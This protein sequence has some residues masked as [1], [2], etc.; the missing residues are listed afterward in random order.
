MI[1]GDKLPL[2]YEYDLKNLAELFNYPLYCINVTRDIKEVLTSMNRRYINNK[3]GFDRW[4][5][6]TN[7]KYAINTW[8]DAWNNRFVYNDS[9]V[10][11]LDINYI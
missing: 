7:F 1:F 8:I 11:Y 9:N 10:H 5:G 4:R 2:Y 6:Y 3:N